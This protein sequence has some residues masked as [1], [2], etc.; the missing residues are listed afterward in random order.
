MMASR[1]TLI[2]HAGHPK[3]GSTAV[4]S[5]LFENGRALAS[6]GIFLLGD[7]FELADDNTIA[8]WPLWFIEKAADQPATYLLDALTQCLERHRGRDVQT[9][10]LSEENLSNPATAPRLDPV[11][12]HFDARLIYYTR[13]QDHFLVAS[14]RQWALKR[15]ATFEQHVA[16]RIAEGK[17]DFAACLDFWEARLGRRNILSRFIDPRFLHGGTLAG[18]LFQALS[19]E[20]ENPAPARATNPSPDRAILLYLQDHHDLFRD[21]HDDA[22]IDLFIRH[23]EGPVVTLAMDRHMQ[24]SVRLAYEEGNQHLLERFGAP[25]QAGQAVIMADGPSERGLY[26]MG[27]R[28]RARIDAI[29]TRLIAS[30]LGRAAEDG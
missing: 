8:D 21:I 1:P 5:L 18:D 13:R 11:L 17:P 28:D 9:L 4:R 2:I 12:E 19:A 23:D 6:R 20:I 22:P 15:G 24:A 14:W 30:Q 29:L 7:G 27:E 25:G 10:V 16:R 26:R 3:C